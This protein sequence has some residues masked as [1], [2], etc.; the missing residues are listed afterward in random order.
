MLKRVSTVFL[1]ILL[2]DL[3]NMA[4]DKIAK[5]IASTGF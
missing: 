2:L 5:F 1:A 4:L 3:F